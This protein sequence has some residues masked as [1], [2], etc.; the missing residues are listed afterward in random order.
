MKTIR[1]IADEIGVSKQAIQKRI[2][3][4]PLCT[5]LSPYI[6]TKNGTK[7]IDVDGENMIVSAFVINKK[8]KAHIPPDTASIDGSIDISMDKTSRSIDNSE[9][10]H[11]LI[12]M[13][14]HELNVK[15]EQIQELNSRLAESS[16]ALVATQN[17]LQAAQMLHGGTMQKHLTDDNEKQEKPRGFFARLFS[18]RD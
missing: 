1:Q 3:R 15:N 7:Y 12:S 9:H 10:I 8:N 5:R 14:Q 11:T 16:S 2:A 17:S 4:E 18:R 13:L 6:C